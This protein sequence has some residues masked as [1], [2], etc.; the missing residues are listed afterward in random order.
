MEALRNRLQRTMQ[1]YVGI[2]RSDSRLAKA[3]A[4]V[5]AL[6]AE[7]RPLFDGSILSDDILELRNMICVAQLIIRCAQARKESRG[8][9]FTTD[10]PQTLD[11]ERHDTV[12]QNKNI[13]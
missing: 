10:Y 12:L 1:R 5:D 8:L 7:A 6:D 4:A 11:S 2:V 9:H 3:A 13:A